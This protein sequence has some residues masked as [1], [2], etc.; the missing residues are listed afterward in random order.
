[1]DQIR[2]SELD[3]IVISSDSEPELTPLEL[4]EPTNVLQESA[5]IT[6][7]EDEFD[8]SLP[9]ALPPTTEE[10]CQIQTIDSDSDDGIINLRRSKNRKFVLA[11]TSEEDSE[12]SATPEDLALIDDSEPGATNYAAI[13]NFLRSSD[14]YEFETKIREK[15][16]SVTCSGETMQSA[17]LA[18]TENPERLEQRRK[19]KITKAWKLRK[20]KQNIAKKSKILFN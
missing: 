3:P 19:R 11:D 20:Q 4:P 9:L 6:H 7:S 1:M 12:D 14:D 16:Q 15:L 5:E 8:D 2:L 13:H 18:I 10:I 17:P